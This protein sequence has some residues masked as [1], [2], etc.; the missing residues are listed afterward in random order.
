MD[1]GSA[2]P[3]VTYVCLKA[4]GDVGRF[5]KDSLILL[6]ELATV[7]RMCPQCRNRSVSRYA[8]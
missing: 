1:W 4:P 8:V 5:P 6:D 3:S 7:D 2:A